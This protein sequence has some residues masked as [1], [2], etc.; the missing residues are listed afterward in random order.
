M[1]H[2][3][4]VAFARLGTNAHLVLA[5]ATLVVSEVVEV[6]GERRFVVFPVQVVP[7]KRACKHPVV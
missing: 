5:D 6:D 1:F 4:R 2:L 3:H 7:N